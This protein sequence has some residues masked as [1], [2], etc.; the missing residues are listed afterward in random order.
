M[1]CS[2]FRYNGNYAED[3][4]V[5]AYLGHVMLAQ[6]S[7]RC[8]LWLFE[9]CLMP[10]GFLHISEERYKQSKSLGLV[11][12]RCA[13][14]WIT[15][16]EE[17]EFEKRWKILFHVTMQETRMEYI[18][19]AILDTL[20]P[21]DGCKSVASEVNTDGGETWMCFPVMTW[22]ISAVISQNGSTCHVKSMDWRCEGACVK[23]MAAANGIRNPLHSECWTL[24]EMT[25]V[26]HIFEIFMDEDEKFKNTKDGNKRR[27]MWNKQEIRLVQFYCHSGVISGLEMFKVRDKWPDMHSS[28]S[29][30]TLQNLHLAVSEI[31]KACVGANVMLETVMPEATIQERKPF[32]KI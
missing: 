29:L 19:G 27:E 15:D 18:R 22:Y 3:H 4:C 16:T 28:F 30:E 1:C 20:K 14:Y 11:A 25:R 9:N 23:F 31:L 2:V 8:R 5:V 10:V 21:L 12:D 6:V 7:L 13:A 24:R 32:S 26:K 17:V